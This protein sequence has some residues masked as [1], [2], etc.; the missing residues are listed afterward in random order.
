MTWSEYSQQGPAVLLADIGAV[1]DAG[2]VRRKREAG[3]SFIVES[4]MPNLAKDI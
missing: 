2:P 4:G 1:F 3:G